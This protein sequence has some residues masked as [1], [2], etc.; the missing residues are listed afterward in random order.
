MDSETA[1]PPVRKPTQ[2]A[3]YEAAGKR[4]IRLS[5]VD[6][7]RAQEIRQDL[8]RCKYI[9]GSDPKESWNLIPALLEGP[10]QDFFVALGILGEAEEI[11]AYAMACRV[12]SLRKV[13]PQL[14]EALHYKKGGVECGG[15]FTG[16]ENDWV[17]LAVS[18]VSKH[19]RDGL[20]GGLCRRL[21]Q[22]L[23]QHR[24]CS[25]WAMVNG[26]DARKLDD[27]ELMWDKLYW[28]ML[29]QLGFSDRQTFGFDR[30]SYYI[31]ELKLK[32]T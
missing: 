8:V 3:T 32:K 31:R 7:R 18:V 21:V 30:K 17:L 25:L 29:S 5:G 6:P 4:A 19:R 13:K 11:I 24:P 14:A 27:R 10:P 28:A 20:G 22:E 2:E 1:S 12:D 9:P 16:G 15:P 23:N 26:S